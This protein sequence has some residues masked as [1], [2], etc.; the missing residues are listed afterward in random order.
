MVAALPPGETARLQVWRHGAPREI[1]VRVGKFESEKLASSESAPSTNGRLGVAAR[2]L[3]AQE[4]RQADVR[5]GVLVES[6]K[7]AAAKA[8]LRPGDIIVS[9]NGEPVTG[10]EQLAT[11]VAKSGKRAAVLVERGDSRLFVPVDLG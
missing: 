9:I 2:D 8:G 3:T 10:V 1:E 11:L 7:G 4:A 5:S 6:V